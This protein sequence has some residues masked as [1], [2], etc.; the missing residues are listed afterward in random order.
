MTQ[1]M[2]S[3]DDVMAQRLDA[4]TDKERAAYESSRVEADLALDIAQAIYDA[5]VQ[6]GLTQ[7]QLAKAMGVTQSHVSALEGGAGIPSLRTL[8]KVAHAV[9]L[10]LKVEIAA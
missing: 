2:K 9:G 3:Y 7:A 10:H 6:A 1:N 4:M 8:A 5:R